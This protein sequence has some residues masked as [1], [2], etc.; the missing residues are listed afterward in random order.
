MENRINAVLKRV[1]D[2]TEKEVM[3][4]LKRGQIAKWDSL[5]HMDLVVSLEREFNIIFDLDDIIAF[6]SLESIKAVVR[7]KGC[8]DA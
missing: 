3:Q 7:Q 5:T 2:L 8:Q 4:D 6:D 1:F